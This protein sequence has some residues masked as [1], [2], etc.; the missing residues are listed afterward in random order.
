MFHRRFGM[1]AGFQNIIETNQVTLNV[2]IR[3]GDGIS[4]ARLRCEVYNDRRLVIR[5][6]AIDYSAVRQISLDKMIGTAALG[7]GFLQFP[8]VATP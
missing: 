4:Y 7:S 1:P 2:C 8:K 3:I 6:E 5:K